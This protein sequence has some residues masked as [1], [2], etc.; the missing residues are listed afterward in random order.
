[1]ISDILI[2]VLVPAYNEEKNIENCINSILGGSVDPRVQMI[3]VDDGSKDDTLKIASRLKKKYKNLIVETQVNGGV[4]SARNHAMRLAEGR[5]I[6]FADADDGLPEQWFL[7]VEKYL[8]SDCKVIQGVLSTEGQ[9]YVTS[10][11]DKK[12]KSTIVC[13]YLLNRKRYLNGDS[14]T[15][16][17]VN[18]AHGVNGKLYDRELIKD[19]RFAEQVPIGEDILFYLDV[20]EKAKQILFVDSIFYNIHENPASSTRRYNEKILKGT[21]YFYDALVQRYVWQ[22]KD[23]NLYANSCFQIYWHFYCGVLR[24]LARKNELS[25]VEKINILKYALMNE[26]L[27]TA[28]KYLNA[29]KNKIRQLITK[30]EAFYIMLIQYKLISLYVIFRSICR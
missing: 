30:R 1:M 16:N 3:V 14:F 13:N 27:K 20:L 24:N 15:D 5:W 10:G 25:F 6:M 21:S 18:S 26:T 28:I 8:F 23:V 19:I 11:M 9:Q 4:S 29:N 12:I 2:S 7:N 22:T 17:L